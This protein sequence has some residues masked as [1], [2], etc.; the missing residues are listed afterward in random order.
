MERMVDA[1]CL[2]MEIRNRNREPLL[3]KTIY[4]G[5]GTPSVLPGN[6]LE[7]LMD[8]IQHLFGT[9]DLKEITLEANPDDI[10][11]DNLTAWKSLGINRLSIGLQTFD[12]LKLQWMNRIHT[13]EEGINSVKKARDAGFENISLDLM[14]QLPDTG[15][16]QLKTDIEQITGLNPRH[17]SAYGLTLE[18]DT[19]FGR[20]HKKGRI[21]PLPDEKAAEQFQFLVDVMEEKGFFQY[22]ISNFS[23]LGFEAV[24]NTAYWF[25]SPYVG[26][27]PGA[28]GFDGDRT[29]YE[30]LP[31]NSL[32]MRKLLKEGTLCQKEEFLSPEDQINEAI[33]TRLRTK[34][35]L[36]L[37]ELALKTRI[38]LK[39]LKANELEK[40]INQGLVVLEQDNILLSNAGKLLA[41]H[42]ASRLMV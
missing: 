35:G 10:H 2:E 20:W 27:G 16:D 39:T 30:N 21:I 4:F 28:H 41:D 40:L 19:A 23:T 11:A 13:S 9:S 8:R 6:L 15:T 42:I 25:Q 29:R 36:N 1:M 24:H 14:Y 5:G 18:P 12:N 37:N 34:W 26:I 32:Y 31:N 17:I 7:K 38:D 3:L 33:L 22:E